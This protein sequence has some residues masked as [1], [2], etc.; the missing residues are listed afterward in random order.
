MPWSPNDQLLANPVHCLS[1]LGQETGLIMAQGGGGYIYDGL[2]DAVQPGQKHHHAGNDLPDAV[3]SGQF[4]KFYQHLLACK[5]RKVQSS[6][7]DTS[8][9]QPLKMLTQTHSYNLDDQER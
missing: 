3:K 9:T 5:A 6:Q 1:E 2:L 7:S 4:V 8:G